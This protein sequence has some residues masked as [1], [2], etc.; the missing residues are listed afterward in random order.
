M[1]T[2]ARMQLP[3]WFLQV[4]TPSISGG[5]RSENHVNAGNTYI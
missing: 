1:F 3:A 2:S 4:Q 5:C